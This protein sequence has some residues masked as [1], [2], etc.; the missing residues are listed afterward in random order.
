M[1]NSRSWASLNFGLRVF[2]G[3][4]AETEKERR[5]KREEDRKGEKQEKGNWLVRVQDDGWQEGTVTCRAVNSRLIDCLVRV[6]F[7]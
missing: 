7:D 4:A 5:Q 1:I 2:F 3:I 6:L